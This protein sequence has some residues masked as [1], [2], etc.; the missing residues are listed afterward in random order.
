M[1]AKDE[2]PQHSTSSKEQPMDIKTK[3]AEKTAPPQDNLESSSTIPA[4]SS[5]PRTMTQNKPQDARLQQEP[6]M[7]QYARNLPTMPRKHR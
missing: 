3:Q 4:T 5:S 6:S 2:P 7:R 1:F